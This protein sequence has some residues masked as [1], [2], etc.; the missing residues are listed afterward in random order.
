MHRIIFFQW[1]PQV[2]CSLLNWLFVQ[3]LSFKGI[4]NSATSFQILS[5]KSKFC[6]RQ[7]KVKYPHGKI[8]TS[9]IQR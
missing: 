1:L 4:E 9:K 2:I 7:N 3:G 8:V 6:C 5:Q